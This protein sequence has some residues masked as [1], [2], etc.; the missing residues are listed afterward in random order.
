MDAAFWRGRRVLVT[1][2]TGFKGSWLSVWL[3]RL[4]ADVCGFAL[5]PPTDPSLFAAAGVADG[6]TS[7]TGDVRD[8]RHLARTVAEHG[9]EVVIHLAAQA[10]VRDSYEDPVGTYSTNVMGTVHVLEAARRAGTVRTVLVVT[11][12]KCYQERDLD[13]AYREGDRLGGRDPY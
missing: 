1:G 5:E 7:V 6:M 8:L 9:S 2:H 11:S 12:D 10:L 13:R 3:Q 4:E